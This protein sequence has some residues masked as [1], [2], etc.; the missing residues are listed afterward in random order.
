MMVQAA[1]RL[2]ILAC[3]AIYCSEGDSRFAGQ[4]TIL[5]ALIPV[6]YAWCIWLPQLSMLAIA[7]TVGMVV[8][9]CLI[10]PRN[11]CLSSFRVRVEGQA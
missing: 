5:L 2:A 6:C 10:I 8:C 9:F 4:E 11:V 1:L 7:L 3:T